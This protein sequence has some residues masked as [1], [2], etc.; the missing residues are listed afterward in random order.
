MRGGSVRRLGR[1]TALLAVAVALLV[2]L[3]GP[4]QAAPPPPPPPPNPT[5]NQLGASRA[6]VNARTAQVAGL[7]TQLS[8]LDDRA[9]AIALEL[10]ARQEQANRALVDLQDARTAADA[11]S[12]A[13]ASAKQATTAAAADVEALRARVDEFVSARY[14]QGLD[15]GPLGLLTAPGGPQEVLDRSAFADLVADQQ[16]QVLDSLHRALVARVNAD[17]LARKAEDDARAAAER[18]EQASEAAAA[19]VANVQAKAVAQAALLAQV[20]AQREQVNAQLAAAISSDAGLRAQ[21]DRFVSWQEQVAAAQRAQAQAAAGRVGG[22][23]IVRGAGAV[24]GVIDRAMSQL[25]VQY[26]WGGGN[27]RGP[28]LGVRDGGVADAFGDY[29]HVGFDCSGLMIYAFAGA[30]SGVAALQRLPVPVRS[31]GAGRRPPA[32][33]HAVLRQR[34]RDRARRAVRRQRHDDRG[35]VLR[36]RA[37]RASYRCAPRASC[38]SSPACPDAR[39][40][41]LRVCT[42]GAR[43]GCQRERARCRAERRPPKPSS[44]SARCSRSSGSSSARTGSSSGCS[45][46][47]SPAGHLLLEGVPGV[48]KTLAV[49]TFAKVVGGTFARLQFTPDLV[50]A[51]ILGTRI[52]RQGREEFDVELGPVVANFVLADEINRAPAKVQSAMLE[53]MAERHVSIGGETHPMPDPF[54]VLATQNPIENEGVYPLPEAQRDRF[55]FKILVEYPTVEEE[56]EIVYRMGA[57]RRSPH[58]VLDPAELSRLQDVAAAG[59][60]APR[61]RR[62]RRAPRRGHPHPRRAR[63]R[64]R[65]RLGRLRRLAPRVARHHRRRPRARPGPRPRLR[66]APGRPRRR[67]RRAA[68]PPRALLRRAGRRRADRP[69]RHPR[70]PDRPAAAGH[71]PPESAHGPG[72]SRRPAAPT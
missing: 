50:P 11:A 17:S 12:A 1:A 64:R 47:C 68:P 26:A 59:V 67:A 57:S 41:D 35:A 6:A 24:R 36:L 71:R 53:V 5:D 72:P 48:A 38:P 27:G 69:R 54:L 62:L 66:A 18:A 61:A 39:P 51:D 56:R 55:L 44:S 29:R 31:A 58:H 9:A 65:R 60:R 10:S 49:E 23:G 63:A 34:R 45:S 21:R 8:A 52:Y 3:A 37:V 40:L 43:V 15:I 32:R 22:G 33:R 2:G 20:R 7:T 14:Q 16:Q 42:D 4:A 13:A 28:T 19:T 25:G 30:G 46:G 70:A